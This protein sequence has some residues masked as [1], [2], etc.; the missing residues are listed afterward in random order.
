VFSSADKLSAPP[1]GDPTAEG[2]QLLFIHVICQ[3]VEDH[4]TPTWRHEVEAFFSGTAFARYCA[5]LGWN[6]DWARR[7]IQGFVAKRRSSVGEL[8]AGKA[9]YGG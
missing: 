6:Q 4:G 2:A 1:I 7:R 5:L 3:A 9:E 8:E